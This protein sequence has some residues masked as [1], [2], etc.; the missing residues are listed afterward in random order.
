MFYRPPTH[1]VCVC[2]HYPIVWFYKL[3]IAIE[4]RRLR[5]FGDVYHAYGWTLYAPGEAANRAVRHAI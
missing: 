1:M 5:C 3:G 4:Q 2:L